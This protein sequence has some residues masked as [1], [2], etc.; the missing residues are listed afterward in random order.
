[1]IVKVL[2]SFTIQENFT[3]NFNISIPHGN[4]LIASYGKHKGFKKKTFFKRI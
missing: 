2:Q 4:G 3:S 1:M